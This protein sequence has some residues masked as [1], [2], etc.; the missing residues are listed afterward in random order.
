MGINL[1]DNILKSMAKGASVLVGGIT[2]RAGT[3]GALYRVQ[4]PAITK[5][6][7]QARIERLRTQ[8]IPAVIRLIGN[9]QRKQK[10]DEEGGD[11]KTVWIGPIA[12]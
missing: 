3:D 6:G 2:Y 8:Q 7:I 10:K 9:H 4:H 1:N 12:W 11:E 5:E